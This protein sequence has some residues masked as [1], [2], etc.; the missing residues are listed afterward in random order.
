L[1]HKSTSEI[2][3]AILYYIFKKAYVTYKYLRLG[4]IAFNNLFVSR[5]DKTIIKGVGTPRL[6]PVKFNMMII[7]F[8][9]EVKMDLLGRLVIAQNFVVSSEWHEEVKVLQKVDT[10]K[11]KLFA[12]C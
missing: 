4:D 7:K 8:I 1:L 5:I 9:I 6:V 11:S 3:Y 12:Y 2:H 10:D